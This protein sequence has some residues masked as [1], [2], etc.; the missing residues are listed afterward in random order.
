MNEPLRVLDLF[1]GIGGFSLGLRRA[2]GFRTVAYCEIEAYCQ[3]VLL[4][5]MRDGWLDTAP[6][7]SDIT[8]LDGKPWGGAVDVICGGFPCQDISGAG[9]RAGISGSRSGLWSEMAR[10]IREVAPR[11]VIVE[12]VADIAWRG[13]DRVLGDLADLG[14]DAEW[15][16]VCSCVFGTAHC[17]ER[18]W[19]VADSGGFGEQ[20]FFR[21]GFRA[22]QAG[23]RGKDVEALVPHRSRHGMADTFG[24]GE[25][26]AILRGESDGIPS[27]L[28]RLHAV[29]NAVVPHVVE[30][31]GRGLI[32]V[33]H[34]PSNAKEVK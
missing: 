8:R 24:D 27:R 26:S 9:T 31:I 22:R 3:A 13:I 29:G 21:E 19:V 32:E 2:G 33:T 5:R 4:A 11:F 23:Q 18:A 30:W 28:D 15:C 25:T 1:S 7:H 6:I 16:C 10:I 20:G 14:L 12:N 34:N 17:R